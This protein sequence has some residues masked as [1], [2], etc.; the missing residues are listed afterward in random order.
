MTR[1][2][3]AAKSVVAGVG[4]SPRL[5]AQWRRDEFPRVHHPKSAADLSPRACERGGRSIFTNEWSDL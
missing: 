1:M 4:F 2:T 5:M 3:A